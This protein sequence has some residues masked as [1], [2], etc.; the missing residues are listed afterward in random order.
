MGGARVSIFF[1]KNPNNFFSFIC[2]SGA[3]G[4]ASV[5]EIFITKNQNL[6]KKCFGSGGWGLE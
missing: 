4:G 2:F 6:K 5:S 3:G 1:T